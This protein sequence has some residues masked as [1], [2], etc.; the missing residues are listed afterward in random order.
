MSNLRVAD[1][2]SVDVSV[3]VEE[4][5]HILLEWSLLVL[6]AILGSS[7]RGAGS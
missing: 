4:R 5:A 1:V 2:A 6:Q 3:L 7:H